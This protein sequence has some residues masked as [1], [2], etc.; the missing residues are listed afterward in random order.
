MKI[1]R[2]PHPALRYQAKPVTTIDAEVRKVIDALRDLTYQHEGLGL[3]APQI[4]VPLQIF[5]MNPSGEKEQKEEERVIINPVISMRE[6]SEEREE[7]CLSFPE[8]YQNVRRA[9]KIRLEAYD[10]EGGKID[11]IFEDLPARIVQ[12][13]ADHLHGKL[14]IDYFNTISKLASRGMI[15]QFE[16]D[17][18]K[19]QERGELPSKKEM[20]RRLRQLE[21]QFA[22][23]A[24]PANSEHKPVL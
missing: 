10:P 24:K 15:S 5:F 17:F 23:G 14:F 1:V 8:L 11:M 4:A 19:Q 18:L 2:F 13:E 9:K 3:A 22:E 20:L 21:E 12:H 6:G 16:K 7:G